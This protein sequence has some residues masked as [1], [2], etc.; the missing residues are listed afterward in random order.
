[1]DIYQ[2]EE[3]QVEAIKGYWEENGN[4]IIAGI[5]LGFVGFIGFNYYKDNKLA[6]E[7]AIS[8]SYQTLM[9][10]SATDKQAFSENAEKFIKENST[11]SYASLTALALAKEAA[12]KKDW[13]VAQAQLKAAIESAP[14]DGIKGI[15]S[16][17]LARV[18]IQL[19]QYE[20]A[21]A[22]L[23]KPLPES[24]TAAI[25]EIKGDTYLLQGKNELAR[26]SYQVAIAA[27]GLASS[28]SLQMK[29]DDLATAVNLTSIVPTAK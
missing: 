1:M 18:Q 15:A 24:F 16:L 2:T 8:N 14:T 28:P 19:E 11:T 17:R 10:N 5:V 7:L 23:A 13:A 12:S 20:Q 26:N 3:Q 21:F 29:L 27:D 6:D 25:E 22:T 9:E 4:M